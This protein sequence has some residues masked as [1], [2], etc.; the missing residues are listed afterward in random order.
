MRSVR[1]TFSDGNTITT[2]ING[3]DAAISQYYVGQYFQ[4]GD[5]KECPKD[6][7]VRAVKVEFLED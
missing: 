3:T 7:M 1:V 4:F 6:K 2:Q 5:T